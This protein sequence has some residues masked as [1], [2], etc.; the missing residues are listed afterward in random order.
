MK[1]TIIRR[2]HVHKLSAWHK[3][4]VTSQYW[5]VTAM[6][7]PPTWSTK[8]RIPRY[9][10]FFSGACVVSQFPKLNGHPEQTGIGIVSLG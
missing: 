5:T 6:T 9:F 1:K 10:L 2:G 4:N 8:T 7:L 3:R